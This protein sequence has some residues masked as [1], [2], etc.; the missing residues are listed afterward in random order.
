VP[1]A[2]LWAVA[3][4]LVLSAGTP[5]E[6]SLGASSSTVVPRVDAH[7]ALVHRDVYLMGTRARL[8]TYAADR[9]E[10]VTLL[11]KALRILEG[12]ERELTTWSDQSDISQLNRTAIGLPWR[13]PDHLCRLFEELYEWHQAT[14]GAFDPGIGALT[15]AWNVHEDGRV[16]SRPELETARERSGLRRFEFARATC[17]LTRRTDATIDVGA[18]GKGEALD[19]VVQALAGT[20]WMIDLGGQ[21]SIGGPPP[22][23]G[24]WTIDLAHPLERN[25]TVLSVA[26]RNGSLSTSGGSERDLEAD[27]V[28]VGHILD[29][30]TGKPA[31]FLGSVVVW[32]ERGLVADILSTAL[33]VM[34]PEVGLQWARDRALAVCFLVPQG[35]TVRTEMT[36]LFRRY[37]L[38]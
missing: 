15:A 35:Q 10:G 26:M 8:A 9:D 4:L 23:H 36:D 7:P 25:R 14:D 24:T 5:Q 31:P 13:A 30:R 38:Q 21:V 3:G 18:F 2:A 29:P 20:P 11:E 12:T 32:H 19:R 28:R 16:P 34:G 27:G 22:T 33:Y 37:L 6:R 17:T 1:R